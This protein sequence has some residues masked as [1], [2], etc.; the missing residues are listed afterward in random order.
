MFDASNIRMFDVSNAFIRKLMD[1]VT[2]KMELQ[3]PVI[4]S[5]TDLQDEVLKDFP[6]LQPNRSRQFKYEYGHGTANYSV[7]LKQDELEKLK[8]EKGETHKNVSSIFCDTKNG[9][10][11]HPVV[12]LMK[13]CTGSSNE[14][15][16]AFGECI[17][18]LRGIAIGN[19]LAGHNVPVV[20]IETNLLT[21]RVFLYDS[22]QPHS[23]VTISK[24]YMLL[25]NK[26]KQYTQGEEFELFAQIMI[27]LKKFI[28]EYATTAAKIVSGITFEDS[29]RIAILQQEN[30]KLSEEIVKLQRTNSDMT[31]LITRLNEKLD[32]SEKRN[33]EIESKMK[34]AVELLTASIDNTPKVNAVLPPFTMLPE[35]GPP[36]PPGVTSPLAMLSHT[37]RVN[38]PNQRPENST[39]TASADTQQLDIRKSSSSDE[40]PPQTDLSNQTKPKGKR[41]RKRKS[42][43]IITDLNAIEPEPEPRK[44]RARTSMSSEDKFT[45]KHVLSV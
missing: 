17:A 11:N 22:R 44:K 40:T 30:A 7:D 33:K 5:L 13:F 23:G 43:T 2:Q 39:S 42:E 27:S 35:T 24:Q 14:Q 19:K 37:L 32:Q 38:S 16:K 21:F 41:G 45:D 25:S 34:Q 18:M 15:D 36:R 4:I 12:E 3:Y 31:T 8:I 29:N 1:L 28:C 6:M 9:M 20:L 26:Y 10:L